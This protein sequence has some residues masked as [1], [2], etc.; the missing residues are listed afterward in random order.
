MATAELNIETLEA[1][2]ED[3]RVMTWRFEQLRQAGYDDTAAAD[4]AE[5]ADIDLHLAV[6]LVRAGCSPALALRILC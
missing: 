3:A 6:E 2:S 5:R 4:L 1:S